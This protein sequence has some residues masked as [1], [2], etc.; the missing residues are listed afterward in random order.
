MLAG[1]ILTAGA[2]AEVWR[3]A[4]QTA[5][6]AAIAGLATLSVIARRIAPL[7]VLGISVGALT[8]L[9]VQGIDEFP[10]SLLLAL[11]LA[12]YTAAVLVTPRQAVLALVVVVA[13]AWANSFAARSREMGDYVF[14]VILLAVPWAAGVS[15]R[16]WRE[17]TEELRRLTADLE[18]ERELHA[19]LAVAAERG[20]IARDLHDSLAQ[21]LNTMVMHAEAAEAALD[22][23]DRRVSASLR[24]IQDVGR[25]SLQETRQLLMGLRES[26][27]GEA[28]RIADVHRL[29]DGAREAGF[30]V[31]VSLTGD[32]D[33]PSGPT[34]AAAYRIVQESLTNAVRHSSGRQARVAVTVADDVHIVVTDDG[35]PGAPARGRGLGR[36][37]MRERAVLLG[38]CCRSGF[39]DH[40]FQVE[41]RIPLRAPS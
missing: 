9:T 2:L 6:T 27:E 19:R 16:R 15:I 35:Q 29:A 38:G 33:A 20:R 12:T 1:L 4:D 5:G 21:S 10:V 26:S 28:L 31:D 11:M 41:A 24:R 14:P 40:G 8:L 30:A 34:Q 22:R 3:S 23:D 7:V 25:G 32:V 39:T 17:R 13:A 36:V 37:G 18:A